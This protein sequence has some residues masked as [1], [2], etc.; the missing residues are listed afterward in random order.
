MV[1]VHLTNTLAY[2]GQSCLRRETVWGFGTWF[3]N[4]KLFS[5]PMMLRLNKQFAP[6][7]IFE[8]F[9]ERLKDNKLVKEQTCQ[10]I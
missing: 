7:H 2:L 3:Q 6:D 8:I 1:L 5:P 10:L 4:L 9:I